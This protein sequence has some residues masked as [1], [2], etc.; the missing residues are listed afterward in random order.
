MLRNSLNKFIA[1]VLSYKTLI[2]KLS[3]RARILSL[4]L[5][6]ITLAVF[7]V[8][9]TTFIIGKS[10]LENI[11]A[12][13]MNN[14]IRFVID[15]ISLLS[16]A[17]NSKQFSGKLGYVLASEQASFNSAGLKARIYMLNSSGYEV[18]V[19]N[20]N[21]ESTKES[22]L[23]DEF[24]KEVLKKKKGESDIKIDGE[25]KSVS[26]GYIIEKDWVYIVAVTK[27]S[28][29]KPIYILQIVTLVSGILAIVLAF[30]F[31]YIGTRGLVNTIKEL[32][33]T[34]SLVDKGNLSARVG[35]SG[36]GPEMNT[37]TRRFNL[38][39]TNFE[40]LMREIGGSIENLKASSEILTTISRESDESTTYIHGL[41]QKMADGSIR[42][43]EFLTH[44]KDST[45]NIVN[46]ISSISVQ[47]ED[48][49]NASNVM[50]LTVHEGLKAIEELGEKISDIEEVSNSTVNHISILEKRSNEINKITNTIKGISDQTK[51]LSLNASIEAARAG[52]FGAGFTVV[53]AEIQKL[54]ESSAKSAFEVAEIIKEIK[55][56]TDAVLQIAN[57]GKRISHEGS[58]IAAKTDSAFKMILDKVSETHEHVNFISS[59]ASS[60]SDNITIYID[61]IE[62]VSNIISETVHN[63]Q[64]VAST[65]EMHQN[66]SSG[67][68]G[69]ALDLRNMAVKLN[70]L[71]DEFIIKG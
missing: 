50:L 26:F 18:N 23:P 10:N 24:I 20:V 27:S 70:E 69:S 67:I 64:E 31:S 47:I 41:T 55:K 30:L 42:Q 12:N 65:V 34:V 5:T 28:Y 32:N 36:G 68:S 56:D 58:E 22:G 46:T 3:I 29:L 49:S 66:L 9:S 44:I 11:I 33:R 17:Y 48:T 15:Q 16:G 4:F 45:N 59:N 60:I 57:R 38:M 51:L 1:N 63:S 52:Q 62:K 35:I 7:V 71:K 19:E 53:A 40:T 37:L 14:S 21:E 43:E 13:Q 54:A 6:I 39:L 8:A 61:N 25:L 2:R